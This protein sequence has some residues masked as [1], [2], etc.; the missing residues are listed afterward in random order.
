MDAALKPLRQLQVTDFAV[1]E[2]SVS[3]TPASISLDEVPLDLML[4][5][6]VSGSMF[7]NVS[8]VAAGAHQALQALRPGDRVGLMS[9]TARS[10]LRLPLTSDRSAIENAI[11]DLAQKKNFGGGT[12]IN[13]PILEA[14]KLLIAQSPKQH[15]R[16]ILILTDGLGQKGARTNRVLERLWEGDITLNALMLKPF[17]VALGLNIGSR[18]TS[19]YSVVLKANIDDLVNKSAGEVMKLED[20]SAPLAEILERIRSRYT[21]YYPPLEQSVKDRSVIVTL[22]ESG[23]QRFPGALAI[24]RRQYSV[25]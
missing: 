8:K 16:A 7:K 13:T 12:V 22:S 5:V 21:V 4:V 11:S 23:K 3:R 14:A 1:T 17:F 9:F 6:D 19:P 2:N 24:G 15:R 18:I 25:P 20:S 10:K